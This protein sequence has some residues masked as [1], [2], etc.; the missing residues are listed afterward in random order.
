MSDKNLDDVITDFFTCPVD[1]PEESLKYKKRDIYWED[2][3]GWFYPWRIT[4]PGQGYPCGE[5]KRK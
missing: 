1:L 5:P 3:G 2:S 4:G